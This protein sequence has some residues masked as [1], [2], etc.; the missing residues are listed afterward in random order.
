L[1]GKDAG[2]ERNYDSYIVMRH[3]MRMIEEQEVH[4]NQHLRE[5]LNEKGVKSDDLRKTY[6][7]SHNRLKIVDAERVENYSQEHVLSDK[8]QLAAPLN[9]GQRVVE[10]LVGFQQFKQLGDRVDLHQEEQDAYR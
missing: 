1:D 4:M 3:F 10:V 6:R 8:R 2:N 5:V 9:L 7:L